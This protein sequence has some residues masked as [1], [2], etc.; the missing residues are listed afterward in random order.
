VKVYC[1][2]GNPGK[3]REFQLAGELLAGGLDAIAIEPLAG[4]REIAAPEETG[5]TFEENARL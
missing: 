1:A 3:L 5:A 4:L 2:T